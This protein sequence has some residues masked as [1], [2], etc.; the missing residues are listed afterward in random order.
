M[1]ISRN[2]P[3]SFCQFDVRRKRSERIKF[4]KFENEKKK[5]EVFR[6]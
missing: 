5:N 6:E 2:F 1:S 4:V 3:F